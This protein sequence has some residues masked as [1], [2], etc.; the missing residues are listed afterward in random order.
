MSDGEV[1]ALAAVNGVVSRLGVAREFD[2]GLKDILDVLEPAQIQ[3]QE[4]VYGLRHYR[5]RL[6]LDPARLREAEQRLEAVQSAARKY[7]VAPEQLPEVLSQARYR[8]EE[9][10]GGAGGEA[11]EKKQ[12]EGRDAYFALARGLT[13]IRARAARELA[14]KVTEAMQILAMAGGRFEVSAVAETS[15]PGRPGGRRLAP[16]AR[17]P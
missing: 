7:R 6:E 12:S 3:V 4:A 10:G 9:L 1:S 2:A 14:T 15:C 16:M 13:S 8:L 5:Q 11:L 17:L